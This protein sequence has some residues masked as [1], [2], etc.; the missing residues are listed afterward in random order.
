VN[1]RFVAVA[2]IL[3]SAAS[4]PA[5]AARKPAAPPTLQDL[6]KVPVTVDRAQPVTTDAGQAAQSYEDFL[7]L[8]GSDP[9]L[10]AQALRRLGDLK[11]ASAEALRGEEGAASAAATSAANEAIT[12]Y[13]RL[14]QDY[15]QYPS[16]DAVLYQLARAYETAGNPEKATAALDQLV[17]RY[18]GKAHYDEAQFRRGE[19]EFGA[20]KYADAEGA[21][22]A[23]LALGP[24]SDFYE[25]ALYKRG[26]S[27]L[28]LS[29]DAESSESF[30]RLMDRLLVKDGKLR[31]ASDL[32]RPEHELNDDALRALSITFAGTD[33]VAS[34]EAAVAA[35]GS[36]PYESQLYR[37]LGD[38]YVE[39]ERFQDGAETYRAFSRR[40]PADPEA[41]ELLGLA[42]DAFAKGG[43]TSRVMEAKAETVEQYGPK[44]AYWQS[45]SGNVAPAVDAAVQ[46]DL[47]DLAHYH[48]ALAQKS[49]SATD[50]DAAVRWYREYLEGFN[51]VPEA[52]A[53]RLQLA[54][55]LFDSK[56]YLEAAQEYEL[57]A[58][59]YANATEAGRAGYAALVSYDK[60][61]PLLPEAE[62]P[63]L[64]LRAI[65][66]SL[67]FASTFPD[68]PETPAV[69]ARTTKA[70]FDAGDR[71]RAEAVAQ[72]VLS[73]G[74]RADTGQ[75]LV[76]WTVLAHT[77]FD[78]GR[79]AEAEKAYRE[80]AARL[81]PNDPQRA[82]ITERRAASVYR[83]AEARQV[84]GD[85]A[86]AVNEFLRVASVAPG[87][88]ASA[89]AH[90]DAA[91]LLLTSKQWGQA[92]TV[93]ESFRKTYPQ[94]ELQPDV[95]R[96]LAVAYLEAGRP[97]EA[98]VEFE[99][100]A[101]RDA[102]EPEV[103]RAAQ[104]QA[105]ELYRTSGDAAAATRAYA[106]Y[107]KR[108]P[109]P[110]DVAQE[111][112]HE[113]ADLATKSGDAAARRHWLAEI[114][115]ADAA[116]G[117]SRTDRSRFLAASATIE[118]AAPLD[119]DARGIRLAIPLDKSLRAK[120][121]A[122][123][124][125]LDAYAK[126][127]QYGVAQVSTQAT[128]AM[129]DLYRHLG[130]SLLDSDRPRGLSADELEQYNVL[131]E[132]QAFPFEEKAIVIHEK[133]VKRASE[134][135]WDAWVEKSYADLAAIKPGRYA[136][137]E[138]AEGPDAPPTAAPAVAAQFAAARVSLDA[139]RYDEARQ[140]L[141]AG[142]AASPAN[143]PAL[144]RLGVANRKLG[145]FAASRSSYE[146]AI[147]T[148]S[149]FADAERNLAILL[150]LYLADP[151]AALPHYERYMTLASGADTEVAGWVKELKARLGQGERKVESKP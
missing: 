16:A 128:Y 26:W 69:L 23:V 25:Q 17:T 137:L 133:N 134:G 29:R 58:Y 144:N 138:I 151:A 4:L 34:L 61:E 81:P 56:R 42:A 148:D 120:R 54:D 36:T 140:A 35:H 86:G 111:A 22:A 5:E 113:L 68:H 90:Y 107:V 49:G 78:S 46:K 50:R 40:H 43:F 53:T 117:P 55:L 18:P 118:L 141:E 27:L 94:S 98:A 63:A 112:R 74:P 139:G 7:K 145:R 77:Y 103:R 127:E 121:K 72:Q 3:L 2:L 119:A 24:A 48:H 91:A 14:L 132:E 105:A 39:K 8:E 109:A 44:S 51:A 30:L 75:Q 20:Q 82:E 108:F 47:L 110:F 11:L 97:R 150:D 142:L 135:I 129:A 83:Q 37:A 102:E 114:I 52:A 15:P 33:G 92:A 41:P 123:E 125:A 60:A 73:L 136:R 99:R 149:N 84:A 80:V 147:V 115:A 146:S 38:L 131:L 100:V 71:G 57:A 104:W 101:A 122:M 124:A 126:A 93:L 64:R 70:L 19:L 1:L 116:A 13:Q 32:S 31:P 67:R 96:K 9:V 85:T 59:T 10:R 28:K 79:F 65:D 21:Y 88:T 45:H 106:E 66:S 95:T 89:K 87:S 12:A 76:A 143:A 6:A 130:K 62:R